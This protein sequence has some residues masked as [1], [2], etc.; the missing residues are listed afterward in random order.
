[1]KLMIFGMILGA[2]AVVG[3]VT[4]RDFRAGNQSAQAVVSAAD[5]VPVD[6]RFFAHLQALRQNQDKLGDFLLV[7]DRLAAF[8][9]EEMTREPR[10]FA[11]LIEEAIPLVSHVGPIAA[12]KLEPYATEAV[13]KAVQGLREEARVADFFKLKE[14][15]QAMEKQ[16]AAVQ[17]Q[18]LLFSSVVPVLLVNFW[19][20]SGAGFQISNLKTKEQKV[21]TLSVSVG[22]QHPTTQVIYLLPGEYK[23]ITD[24]T[25]SSAPHENFILVHPGPKEEHQQQKYHAVIKTPYQFVRLG[26]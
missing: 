7:R 25:P 6:T 8:V 22:L 19:T 15:I 9:Q 26:R 3:A 24:S 20:E 12:L 16:V 10:A 1:M 2:A 5:S 13:H 23:V 17:Q 11:A 21:F 4:I 18:A 14:Q